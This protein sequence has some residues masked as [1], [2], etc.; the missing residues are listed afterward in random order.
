MLLIHIPWGSPSLPPPPQSLPLDILGG[1]HLSP[2]PR[3]IPPRGG[4]GH[5]GVGVAGWGA[6]TVRPADRC[7]FL[8]GFRASG[9]SAPCLWP[10]LGSEGGQT[11]Q[12]PSPSPQIWTPED[13]P[14]QIQLSPGGQAAPCPPE[15]ETQA[16]AGGGPGI[17]TAP[18][19]E[20]V[21]RGAEPG[22]EDG[23]P[24]RRRSFPRRWAV[25][26]WAPRGWG[27]APGASAWSAGPGASC[28]ARPGGT[29]P[30]RLPWRVPEGT[31]RGRG[32]VSGPAPAP[33]RSGAARDAG[34]RAA[35]PELPAAP[36]SCM[37]RT[38]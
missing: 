8:L 34:R 2:G 21:A 24:P 37:L 28:S 10:H 9:R 26:D 4:S 25:C 17:R 36:R 23:E 7:H 14:P 1:S 11:C 33:P 6:P 20:G 32:R 31:G 13:L 18:G 27:G 38:R 19:P 15:D 22:G 35:G 16:E 5:C 29:A 30:G 12:P 3:E